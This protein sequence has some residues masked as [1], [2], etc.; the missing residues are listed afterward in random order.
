AYSRSEI[1]NPQRGKE[2]EP[3]HEARYIPP[4]DDYLYE[5]GRWAPGR[6]GMNVI[7]TVADGGFRRNTMNQLNGRL[8]LNF[9]PIDGLA[10][11]GIVAPRLDFNKNTSFLEKIAY[12][13]RISPSIV[14]FNTTT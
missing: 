4:N 11:T 5:D 7:A 6:T 14:I 2:L 9:K 10:L 3:I 1:N 13:D 8:V 12:T